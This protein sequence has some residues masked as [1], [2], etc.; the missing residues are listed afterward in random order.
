MIDNF[1]WQLVT[2]FDSLKFNVHWALMLLAVLWLI[3]IFNFAVG[4]RLNY[5]GILPRNI[6]GLIGIPCSP[7]LH[8][9]F[10]HLFFNSIPLFALSCFLLITGVHNFLV[11][12]AIIMGISGSLTWLFAR[13]GLHIGASSVIM[14][15][16]SY[17]LVNAYYHPS[18]NA[19]VLAG[20]CFYYFGSLFLSIFP[21]EERVS[22]EGHVFG[23]L[24]GLGALWLLK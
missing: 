5:L 12:T 23:F 2:L 6:I 14:G 16:F 1:I 22:W 17:L 3:Q 11:V 21:Q 13:R 4:Y 24:A 7:F 19:W 20:F 18:V 15:Y 9:S 10:T 8:G